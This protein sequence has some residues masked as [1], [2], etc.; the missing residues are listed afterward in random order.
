VTEK[1]RSA[2]LTSQR[3]PVRVW[4]WWPYPFRGCRR[5]LL[6]G[7]TGRRSGVG[8]TVSQ[9]HTGL[10]AQHPHNTGD[11]CTVRVGRTTP[12][13]DSQVVLEDQRGGDSPLTQVPAVTSLM[14]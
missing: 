7:A 1:A 4:S 11:G 9:N 5:A 10:L 8:G 14:F 12:G 6:R 3:R 2:G 13:S